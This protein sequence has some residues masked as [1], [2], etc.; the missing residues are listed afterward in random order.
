VEA[1][2]VRLGGET[3]FAIGDVHGC[4]QELRALLDAIAAWPPKRSARGG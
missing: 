4:A 3:V 1:R 2:P